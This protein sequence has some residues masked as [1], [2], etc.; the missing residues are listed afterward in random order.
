MK[1]SIIIVTIVL[2]SMASCVM[3]NN[4]YSKDTSKVVKNFVKEYFHIL[5][6]NPGYIIDSE[7]EYKT[8]DS[9]T[10]LPFIVES[11]ENPQPFFQR[12]SENEFN[13]LS[14]KNN[15]TTFNNSIIYTFDGIAPATEIKKFNLYTKTKYN[16]NLNESSLI[17]SI[18]EVTYYTPKEYIDNGYCFEIDCATA[19]Y[20]SD[21]DDF[22]KTESLVNFNNTKHQIIALDLIKLKL[23]T[24]PSVDGIYH[25][26][27]VYEDINGNVLKRDLKPIKL[28]GN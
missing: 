6:L 28:K 24:P 7:L 9:I 5:D 11:Y 12:V 2:L 17:N 25:F 27:I 8:I 1:V 26:T 23:I 19:E 4:K 16:N 18:I 14:I 21:I 22:K 20:T 15:D 10:L 13:K 3:G